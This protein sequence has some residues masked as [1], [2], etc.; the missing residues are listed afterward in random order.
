MAASRREKPQARPVAPAPP[1]RTTT[2]TGGA[3]SGGAGW[4]LS[5]IPAFPPAQSDQAQ[6]EDQGLAP[7]VDGE[8]EAGAA[9]LPVS[10]KLQAAADQLR[11]GDSRPGPMIPVTLDLLSLFM[12]QAPRKPSLPS[13]FKGAP[14]KEF[15]G[16]A[17]VKG[18]ADANE[19]DANDVT[20]NQLGDCGLH[21]A[22][23]AIARVNP[24]AIKD[25]I[26]EKADGTY[27]VT[28]HFKDHIWS[29]KTPHVINVTPTFPTDAAGA[30]LFSQRG[31]VGPD[32]PE[33]WA[34][35]IEKAFAMHAGGYD[36]AEGIWDHA[37]LDLL[38][39]A[40]ADKEQ[41]VTALTEAEMG[42]AINAKVSSGA[43]AVTANTSQS[44]LDEWTRSEAGDKEIA[45]LG[46]VM[47]HAY[48]IVA[49]DEA[50][51]T[52]DL[53]NPWGYQDLKGLS[54]SVFRKYFHTWS[55]VKV[56]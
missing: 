54:F 43:H 46:I 39:K 48:A 1:V 28:L 8:R 50:A 3:A 49:V 34:M 17:F 38:A 53:R 4:D 35:L 44:R 55:S 32:G 40:D 14:Y 36:N 37:A 47:I 26:T 11:A 16:R 31:D 33:L 23:I 29:D 10:D 19:V 51:K 7:R 52:L 24:Q 22:M 5:A 13:K 15:K 56:K 42:K 20:Q 6:A 21:S 2:A 25:L 27:D 45:T 18:A 30:P 12:P 41:K 9:L